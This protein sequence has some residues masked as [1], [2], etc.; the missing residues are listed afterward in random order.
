MRTNALVKF[1]YNNLGK[2]ILIYGT[3]LGAIHAINTLGILF[4]EITGFIETNPQKKTFLSKPV[5]RF[6][7]LNLDEIDVIVVAVEKYV[8]IKHMLDKESYKEVFYL[9]EKTGSADLEKAISTNR[10]ENGVL[11]GKRTYGTKTTIHFPGCVSFIGAYCSIN[12]TAA[13]GGA[14]HPMHFVS[15][16]PIFYTKKSAQELYD[17]AFAD[18]EVDIKDNK[19]KIVIGNDVW[20]GTYATILPGVTIGD[21]AVIGAG[22][23]V[24][25]DVPPYAVVGGTPAKV[26]K[27][28]FSQEVIE[29]LLKIKWWDWP[30]EKIRENAYLFYDVEKFVEHFIKEVGHVG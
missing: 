18:E 19:S 13:I 2:N 27:Y 3:G 21:G 1:V 4:N 25:K 20:I 16:H 6:S 28:R 9:F 7:D 11:I 14:N 26:I 8:E 10:V 22:A 29:G 30:D 23:V 12:Y 15:T 24:T 5:F 17:I